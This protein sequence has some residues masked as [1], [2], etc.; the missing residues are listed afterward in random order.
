MA[1][2]KFGTPDDLYQSDI[3]REMSKETKLNRHISNTVLLA[4]EDIVSSLVASGHTVV[5]RRLGKFSA[6]LKPARPG[7]DIVRNI[8]LIVPAHYRPILKFDPR[9]VK[10]I[11]NNLIDK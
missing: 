2:R 1:A 9:F 11:S 3:V 5:F 7:K 8:D 4:F 6:R 10:K